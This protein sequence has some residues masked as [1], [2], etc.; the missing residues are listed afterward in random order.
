MRLLPLLV[1]TILAEDCDDSSP[2]AIE[3]EEQ[4]SAKLIVCIDTCVRTILL[5]DHSVTE[6]MLTRLTSVPVGVA[7][8]S[9]A[10]VLSSAVRH[11][12]QRHPLLSSTGIAESAPLRLIID[13]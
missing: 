7:V 9:V 5:A 10:H 8:P 6:S 13:P 12:K 11:G 4:A 1:T 2:D 3:C